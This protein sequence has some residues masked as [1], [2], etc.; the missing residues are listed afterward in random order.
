MLEE[1]ITQK[2]SSGKGRSYG[3]FSERLNKI[4]FC[5]GEK[6]ALMSAAGRR[7]RQRKLWE[8]SELGRGT[9]LI[10]SAW[11]SEWCF[12]CRSQEKSANQFTLRYL[13]NN[14]FQKTSDAERRPSDASHPREMP[15]R[16]RKKNRLSVACSGALPEGKHA[17]LRKNIILLVKL[18]SRVHLI[19]IRQYLLGKSLSGCS[20]GK[21]PNWF[22]QKMLSK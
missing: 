8:F 6:M 3:T 15:W 20:E 13:L 5:S 22:T 12:L 2:F 21:S 7:G 10:H 14:N 1:N 17:V 11:T 18:R 9:R 4:G 19:L 16:R